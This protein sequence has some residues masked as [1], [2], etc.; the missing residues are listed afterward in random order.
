MRASE[1]LQSYEQLHESLL[2]LSRSPLNQLRSI[3]AWLEDLIRR[4]ALRSARSYLREIIGHLAT[5]MPAVPAAGWAPSDFA[6]LRES[7]RQAVDVHGDLF[8]PAEIASTLHQ[9]ALREAAACAYLGI[10]HHSILSP[11]REDFDRLIADGKTERTVL[12]S[13]TSFLEERGRRE[14]T[15]FRAIGEEWT[16]ATRSDPAFVRIPL[17][18]QDLTRGSIPGFYTYGRIALLRMHCAT[19]EK[20][21]GSDLILF[22]NG[23]GE[24]GYEGLEKVLT[25]A[26]DAVRLIAGD[27]MSGAPAGY[28]TAIP[29][30]ENPSDR[31]LG[32]SLG[33]G[34]GVLFFSQ[35]SLLSR[36]RKYFVPDGSTVFTGCV[37]G[38][39]RVSPFDTGQ[40]A[41][42]VETFFYSP[43]AR[44]I[45]PKENEA[46]AQETL[47]SLQRAYPS[48][49]PEITP[50]R[51]LREAV[52]HRLAVRQY[53]FTP[54]QRIARSVKRHQ[55]AIA[56]CSSALVILL[57]GCYFLL[58]AD[59]DD[60]PAEIRMENNYYHVLNRNGKELWRQMIGTEERPFFWYPSE[61]NYRNMFYIDDLDSD[62]RNE[63]LLT[64][65]GDKKGV[66]DKL[67][68]YNHDGSLRWSISLGK[69]TIY[70][71]G[72]YPDDVY[73]VSDIWA[74]IFDSSGSKKILT[75]S[76]TNHYSTFVNI[77]NTR[78]SIQGEYLHIGT[79]WNMGVIWNRE[80]NKYYILLAGTHNGFH[81]PVVILLDPANI[82]G[83]SLQENSHRLLSPSLP[84]AQEVC[85]VRFPPSAVRQYIQAPVNPYAILHSYYGTKIKVI[86]TEL[87]RN[88]LKDIH[89]EGDA[90]LLYSFNESLQPQYVNTSTSYDDVHD[91]LRRR[92]DITVP[93]D[94]A[95]K[96][97]LLS[98][99][100]FWDGEKFVR[101]F[102]W[103]RQYTMKYSL[104]R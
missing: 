97:Q 71:E 35:F 85:Y 4:E 5:I 104:N 42:K 57:L 91:L 25:T 62:G 68:C 61:M 48:R 24:H 92:G 47:E 83:V 6:R 56:L 26:L 64:S 31:Y 101:H 51:H 88:I 32:R 59:F 19:R 95:Y 53:S 96:R 12:D 73:S 44:L 33:L 38:D 94:S 84:Q 66:S 49:R 99:L 46:E 100:E 22:P 21:G 60:N 29:S 102:T 93:L 76:H 67:Y 14:A 70:N 2:F 27:Y 65:F 23:S 15:I 30:F 74:G 34:S 89:I 82:N 40:I 78:G 79:I 75:I 81:S 72:K 37:E 8:P 9:L 50:A 7:V 63:V 87:P 77:L 39:G 20:A 103:N 69:P 3:G 13:Y 45:L 43:Y 18:E 98:R 1:L 86:T 80:M 36:D 10:P 54:R 58:V 17:L 55:T 16:A 28:I 90:V 52:N 41:S 11:D